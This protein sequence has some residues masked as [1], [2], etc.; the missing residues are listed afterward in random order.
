MPAIYVAIFKNKGVQ[1]QEHFTVIKPIGHSKLWPLFQLSCCLF[2]TG[3]KMCNSMF[4][5]CCSP[6]VDYKYT[7][8]VFSQLGSVSQ[9]SNQHNSNPSISIHIY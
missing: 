4:A 1:K 7:S 2:F 5:L 6:V 9:Q 3:S 8:K